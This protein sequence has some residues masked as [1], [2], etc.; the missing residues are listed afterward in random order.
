MEALINPPGPFRE[1]P[2]ERDPLNPTTRQRVFQRLK[3]FVLW[4]LSRTIG[5][6]PPLTTG[7]DRILNLEAGPPS[8]DGSWDVNG[9]GE[10]N[11]RILRHL[12]DGQQQI[13]YVNI[14]GNGII[15]DQDRTYPPYIFEGLKA[16]K[17][18]Q[19][20]TWRFLELRPRNGTVYITTDRVLPH[21]V[22]PQM[23]LQGLPRYN[24]LDLDNWRAVHY[25]GRAGGA[26]AWLNGS[27]FIFKYRPW[28]FLF[29]SLAHEILIYH[30]LVKR[31]FTSAPGLKAYIYEED[32]A[33]V[34]GFLIEFIEGRHAT[35]K[36]FDICKNALIQLHEHDFCH[37]DPHG[38]NMLITPSGTV[39][40]IDFETSLTTLRRSPYCEIGVDEEEFKT[41]T[42]KE[43]DGFY[44]KL[45][46]ETVGYYDD[47]QY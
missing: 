37:G 9:H 29:Q 18:W 14:I 42:K 25:G 1:H 32:P 41:L 35:I 4:L 36:D 23:L 38:R 20:T 15:P 11:L 21:R 2:S 12:D 17:I 22:P 13:V 44:E 6:R 46:D 28:D 39:V 3:Q 30:E 33:R 34:V 24:V 19:D 43:L 26:K 47:S 40:F 45:S 16:M 27:L 31:G 8:Y 10:L 7:Q 5:Y